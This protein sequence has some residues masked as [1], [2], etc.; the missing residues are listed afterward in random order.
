MFAKL[1]SG[2]TR[3]E[4]LTVNCIPLGE[5]PLPYGNCFN[6]ELPYAGTCGAGSVIGPPPH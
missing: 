1:I 5:T 2:G 3:E 6:G 4:V